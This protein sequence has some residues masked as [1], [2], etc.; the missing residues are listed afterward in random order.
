MSQKILVFVTSLILCLTIFVGCSTT[1]TEEKALPESASTA[2]EMTAPLEP[3]VEFNKYNSIFEE[4]L[5]KSGLQIENENPALKCTGPLKNEKRAGS[6]TC[7]SESGKKVSE[8]R[9]DKGHLNG[10]LR[11]YDSDGKMESEAYW[12]KGELNGPANKY[13][14]NGI[15][16]I[17][18]KFKYGKVNG[19]VIEKDDQKHK[20]LSTFFK[21]GRQDGRQ[22]TFHPN[23]NV[24]S[25]SFFKKGN[26]SGRFTEWYENGNIRMEGQYT[27]G[28]PVGNWTKWDESGESKTGTFESLA[29][30]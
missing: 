2:P 14:S 22:K 28:L 23:G 11:T 3:Q 25:R 20:I 30:P 4:F 5:K 7:V 19:L 6:W 16:Q 27:D 18:A 8:G 26:Q 1:K 29:V 21:N 9:F 12:K 17:S 13:F 15:K 24:K 10:W